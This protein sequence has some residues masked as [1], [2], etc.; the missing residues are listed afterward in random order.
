[1]FPQGLL[2]AIDLLIGKLF[3]NSSMRSISTPPPHSVLLIGGLDPTA[4]AGLA[5]DCAS[6][7]A[8]GC[9]P[10]PTITAITAQNTHRV[11]NVWA[12]TAEQLDKQLSTLLEE[13]RPSAIKVGMLPNVELLE[14]V[15]QHQ[16]KLAS[17]PFVVDPVLLSSSNGSLSHITVAQFRPL[18]AACTVCTPNHAEAIALT[19]A[20][21]AE[22]AA[23]EIA[24]W[25]CSVLLTGTDSSDTATIPHT[26]HSNGKVFAFESARLSGQF[27]GSGCTLASGIAASLANGH[28]LNDSIS[29][30]LKHVDQALRNAFSPSASSPQLIP[31]H[32]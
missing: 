30:S 28:S 18:L 22:D 3:H 25:G 24:S 19:S 8:L 27:H 32:L 21:N 12:S 9:H 17:T 4:G 23:Q 2:K 16:A 10:L 29:L 31:R 11:S 26:L 15:L 5:A 7:T 1:M 14:V 6:V 20:N 13:W